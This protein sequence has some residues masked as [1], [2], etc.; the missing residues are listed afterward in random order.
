[1]QENVGQAAYFFRARSSINLCLYLVA[2]HKLK[3]ELFPTIIDLLYAAI[4]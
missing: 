1:M 3:K 2:H 4:A